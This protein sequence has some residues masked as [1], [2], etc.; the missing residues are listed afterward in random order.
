[1]SDPGFLEPVS[2]SS[3][4]PLPARRGFPV[5]SWQLLGGWAVSAAATVCVGAVTGSG[6]AGLCMIPYFALL[7][8]DL[9]VGE[10]RHRRYLRAL[11][12]WQARMHVWHEARWDEFID[13]RWQEFMERIEKNGEDSQ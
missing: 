9:G 2:Y 11:A 3:V 1:M 13:Q 6:L 4:E 10:W 7:C 12:A 5:A 8:Y